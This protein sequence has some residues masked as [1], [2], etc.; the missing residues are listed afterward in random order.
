MEYS[1]GDFLDMFNDGE[2]EV[3]KYFNDYETWFDILKKK[4][5]MSKVDP[6][7]ASESEKWQNEYLLWLYEN[8]KEKYYEWVT[9]ILGDVELIG[10]KVYWIGER[11]DLSNLF[12]Q[13]S[14][15]DLS[16]D[17][18]ENLLSDDADVFE[19]YW[20]TTDD[21]YRDVVEELNEKNLVIFKERILKELTG[22]QLSPETEE[23]ELIAAEQGHDDFWELNSEN[24]SRIIDD[25]ESMKSLLDDELS[26]I[27]H[28]L[29]SI[30]N[31]SYN[32]AY[33]SETYRLIFKELGDYFQTDGEWITK[34]HPWKKD[35]MIQMY[36]M[37]ISDF[38]GIVNDYLYENKGYG[39]SGNLDNQGSFLKLIEESFDCLGVYP[40]DYPNPSEVDKNINDYFSDYF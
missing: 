26:D 16:R 8:N 13:N 14:R 39:S 40:P 37:E 25:S 22:K 35:V 2:L 4:N 21:V 19:P 23:M 29:Y 5:L 27:K 32:S 6:N 31:N 28:D 18:I 12:C 24:V 1:I 17:T 34:K 9:K 3:E 36:K 10:N 7:K 33:E 15:G 30:H 20:D 38:E 11:K